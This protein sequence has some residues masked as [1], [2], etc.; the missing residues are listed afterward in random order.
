VAF[1]L[2]DV[3]TRVIPNEYAQL[4]QYVD[5]M[6]DTTAQIYLGDKKERDVP[7]LPAQSKAGQYLKF[8]TN[9]DGEPEMPEVEWDS[10]FAEAQYNKFSREYQQWNNKRLVWLD[11][12]MQS[13]HYYKSL[14]MEAADEAINNGTSN[15]ALEFYV[16]RYLTPELAL[17]MKRLR[18]PVGFCS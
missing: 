18:Q 13:G 4:I 8:A 6:I 5:C 17:K 1:Y 15:S 10:P 7:E 2:E 9:F 3:K 11:E 16:E 12:K 14:L